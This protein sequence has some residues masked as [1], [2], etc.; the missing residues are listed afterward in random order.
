MDSVNNTCS[1]C[2]LPVLEEYY[3]C[4]NCGNNLKEKIVPIST[5]MQIGFYALAIFLPPLGFWPGIKYA[6]KKSPQA[7]K[8]V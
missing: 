5:I 8:L 4:P 2:H 6:M 3:F 7:K 1:V